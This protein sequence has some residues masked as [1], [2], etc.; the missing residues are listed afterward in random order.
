MMHGRK[1]IEILAYICTGS[2][3]PVCFDTFCCQS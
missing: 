3:F 1:N 2:I